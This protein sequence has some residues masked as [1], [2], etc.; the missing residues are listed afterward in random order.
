MKQQ[1]SKDY[2]INSN[3]YTEIISQPFDFTDDEIIENYTSLLKGLAVNLTRSQ[4]IEIVLTK[5][6][7]LFTGAMMFFNY[8]ENLV[9]TASRTVILTILKRKAYIVHQ[10][11]IDQFILDSGFFYNTV[12]SIRETVTIIN[13]TKNPSIY[14]LEELIH[15]CYDTLYFIN[16]IMQEGNTSFNIDLHKILFQILVI[17]IFG[18]SIITEKINSYHVS[19]PISLYLVSKVACIVQY[20][21]LILD[22]TSL[23][24]S[25]SIPSS[26]IYLMEEPPTRNCTSFSSTEIVDNP[27]YC[28]ILQFLRC[29]DDNLIALSLN[30]IKICIS[31]CSK[32]ELD[33]LKLSEDG[34]ES[35]A[36]KLI[37]MISEV[38]VIDMQFRFSTCYLASRLLYDLYN[39]LS[40]NLFLKNT[41]YIKNILNKYSE[42]A[43]QILEDTK[44]ADFFIDYFETQWNFI[45]K[46]KWNEKT[47]LPMHFISPSIDESSMNIPL[48]SRQY[49][50]E[51]ELIITDIRLYLLYRKTT[52]MLLN[53]KIPSAEEFPLKKFYESSLNFNSIYTGNDSIFKNNI[54]NVKIKIGN[55]LYNKAVIRNEEFFIMV[56]PEPDGNYKLEYISHFKKTLVKEISEP[57][58]MVLVF[59]SGK[60]VEIM[61]DDTIKWLSLKN[62]Y[63]KYQKTSKA[64][65]IKR[66]Q[67]FIIESLNN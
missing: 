55:G 8:H 9:K 56:T 14:K 60:N 42:I 2:L 64:L 18:S 35:L 19:I 59:E 53:P 24:L 17:Q 54:I 46:L 10:N 1:P 4:L 32:Q 66:I 40:Q 67:S 21:P 44:K 31:S 57:R 41:K 22:I 37:N 65:E 28:N 30:L 33:N 63:E 23:I 20:K 47:E 29:R 39:I 58:L 36:A 5:H 11:E 34:I 7:S 16:D 38:L 26:Y 43:L 52:R 62:S 61:F 48:E 45:E 50:N 27:V 13:K 15:D 6:Y 25:Q 12:N 51:T 49:T 3:F